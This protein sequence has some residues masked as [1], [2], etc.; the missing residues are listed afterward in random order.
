M[1]R[2]NI[3]KTLVFFV[4]FTVMFLFALAESHFMQKRLTASGLKT[5]RLLIQGFCRKFY[6]TI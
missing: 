6:Q 2:Y 5:L 4:L 1:N 3:S